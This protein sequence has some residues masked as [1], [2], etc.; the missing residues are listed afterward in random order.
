MAVQIVIELDDNASAGVDKL[1]GKLKGIDDVPMGGVTASLG[2]IGAIA[3]GVALA[4]VTALA[5]GF[6]AFA[7]NAVIDGMAFEAQLDAIAA[8]AGASA[9]EMEQ[10]ENA[11]VNLSMNPDYIVNLEEAGQAME[12]LAASGASV[13]E[14][15]GGAAEASVLLANA[16]GSDFAGAAAT[17]TDVMSLFGIQAEDMMEA[18]NGIVSVTD[19]SK[20]SFTDYQYALAAAGS[21]AATTGME[22]D[23]LNATI[24]AIAPG[25]AS[26]SDA[27]TSLKTMLQRLAAPTDDAQA[28]MSQ[29]GISAYNADGSFREMADVSAD[30]YQALYGVN[31]AGETLTEQQRAQALETMFGADAARAAAEIAKAGA[32]VYTDLGTAI[33][34]TGL[35]QAA[36]TAA[37]DD[38]V[39]TQFELIEAQQSMTDAQAAAQV[40]NDNLKGSWEALKGVVDALGWSFYDHVEPGLRLLTNWATDFLTNYGPMAIDMFGQWGEGIAKF[41]D[42][43]TSFF[44]G[45]GS[46]DFILNFAANLSNMISS[47]DW[48]VLGSQVGNALITGINYFL[49]GGESLMLSLSN[50]YLSIQAWIV[51]QDWIGLGNSIYTGMTAFLTTFWE[52]TSPYFAAWFNSAV[53]WFSEQ[54]WAGTG[55]TIISGIYDGIIAS[56]QLVIDAVTWY[57]ETFNSWITGVDWEAVGKTGL[58]AVI[59]GAYLIGES[60]DAFFMWLGETVST[61]ILET[62]W[63]GMGTDLMDGVVAGILASA[64]NVINA[65]TGV[66]SG[67]WTAAMATIDA[68][69]PSEL[70]KQTVGSYMGQGVAE[71]ITAQA[72]AVNSA[73]SSLLGGA[74]SA[75]GNNINN[76]RT[77]NLNV[78]VQTNSYDLGSN[79]LGAMALYGGI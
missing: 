44:Q 32:V 21:V 56:A 5:A 67:A 20:F 8:I 22:F 65:I 9:D 64:Q 33:A 58:E 14:I 24:A 1:S 13:D 62:D 48:G 18:V 26:G 31:A 59:A 55:E 78:N 42:Y 68:N 53:T 6:A 7:T 17:A 50:M 19:A 77:F 71:G 3:G 47:I 16:T 41:G 75:G 25:F 74:T 69:S 39:I 73:M 76:S 28:L 57:Y 37:M 30:L 52:T 27:G 60:L 45:G 46:S 12:A 63:A 36:L 38:G 72:P 49:G 35:D 15:L 66:L 79:A 11:A 29:L 34:Q 40:R 54:D 70:Y 2:N 10:L 4:G 61:K 51:S 23:D 43:I